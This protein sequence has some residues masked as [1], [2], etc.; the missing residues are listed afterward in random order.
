MKVELVNKETENKLFR[1]TK[2]QQIL[3]DFSN[4]PHNAVRIVFEPGE[5]VN[6]HS[7]QSSYQQAIKRQHLA[8]KARILNG[9]LYLIKTL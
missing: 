8:V 1:L 4:G 2:L 5:Y 7:A 9:E 3:H 6:L